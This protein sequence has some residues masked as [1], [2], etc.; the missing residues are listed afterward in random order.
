MSPGVVV[1][2]GGK[3]QAVG[4]SAPVPAGA[5]VIDLGDATLLP[6][7]LDAHTHIAYEFTHD[8]KQDRL[9]VLQKSIPEVAHESSASAKRSLMAGFTTLRD[10]GSP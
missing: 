10:L 6:G 9:D 8:W 1:V 5:E 2:A 3:I 4:P 7:F